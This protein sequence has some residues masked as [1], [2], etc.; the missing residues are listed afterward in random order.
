MEGFLTEKTPQSRKLFLVAFLL[1]ILVVSVFVS[2]KL[3]FDNRGK[4]FQSIIR[5]SPGGMQAFQKL[6]ELTPS[7]AIVFD[8][9]R[10]SR[11]YV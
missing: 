7:D 8:A 1:V 10:S 9:G 11:R 3:D 2:L 6:A 4:L 5:D